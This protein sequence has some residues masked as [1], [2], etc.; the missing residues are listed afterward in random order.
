M[1]ALIIIGAVALLITILLLLPLVFVIDY[2]KEAE[3]KV[4]KVK[5]NH[6]ISHEIR[7]TPAGNRRTDTNNHPA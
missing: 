5:G 1:I 6:I 7:C 2:D 4:Q 3:I